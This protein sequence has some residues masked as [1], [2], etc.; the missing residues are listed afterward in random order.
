MTTADVKHIH[1]ARV[2]PERGDEV[3]GMRNRCGYRAG[4]RGR[5]GLVEV[6]AE[7]VVGGC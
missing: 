7:G 6:G 1:S 5:W 3:M 2:V 4:G